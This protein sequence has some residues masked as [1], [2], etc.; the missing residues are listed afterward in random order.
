MSVRKEDSD[1]GSIGVDLD[2]GGS[3]REGEREML[4]D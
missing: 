2:T 4:I 3:V 1:S